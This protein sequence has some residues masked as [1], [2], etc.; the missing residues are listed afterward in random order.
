MGNKSASI[1]LDEETLQI[2]ERLAKLYNKS[3]PE[4]IKDLIKKERDASEFKITKGVKK[5]SGILKTNYDYR[6]LRDMYIASKVEKY[7]SID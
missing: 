6:T 4:T 3:I 2:A 1:V 5:I 7:E